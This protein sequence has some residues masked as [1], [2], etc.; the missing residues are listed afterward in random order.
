MSAGHILVVGSLNADLI[1]HAPRLPRSGETVIGAQLHIAAGGKGANQAVA[2]AR[3]GAPVAM[4]GRVGNDAFAQRVRTAL[5]TAGVNVD[6][7]LVD[8]EA[9]TGTAQIVVDAAGRN[10]IVVAS[11]AN[12]RVDVADVTRA[13][14]WNGAVMV[15]LQLEIPLVAVAAAVATAHTRGVPVILN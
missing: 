7:L 13:G 12:A 3:L 8:P 10:A 2:A 11:G 6:A 9:A 14:A 4:L 1:M 15:A 5:V